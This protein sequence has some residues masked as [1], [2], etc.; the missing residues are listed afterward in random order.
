MGFPDGLDFQKTETRGLRL[1]NMLVNQING[2]ITLDKTEG[3]SFKIEFEK[4]AYKE[5]I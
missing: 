4:V 5:R 3:T 2:V 1:V